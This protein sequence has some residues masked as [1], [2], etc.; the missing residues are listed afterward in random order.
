VRRATAG[1]RV[2]GEPAQLVARAEHDGFDAAPAGL[3]DRLGSFDL[4]GA[5][6]GS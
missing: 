6:S 3:L 2:L 1:H 5:G 4:A